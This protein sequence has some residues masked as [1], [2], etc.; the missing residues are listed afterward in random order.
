MAYEL[1]SPKSGSF[2]PWNTQHIS[3]LRQSI[4]SAEHALEKYRKNRKVLLNALHDPC[5]EEESPPTES[6]MPFNELDNMFQ[7]L[8][9]GVVDQN[10]TLRI[11]K[12]KSQRAA[13]MLRSK[14]HDWSERVHM[15][16]SLQSLFQECLLRWGIGYMGYEMGKSGV[17]PYLD[18]LDFDD[19]FI[20]MAGSDENDIDFEG[21]RLCRRLD[22]LLGNPDYNQE[23]VQKL[24]VYQDRRGYNDQQCTLYDRVDLTRTY[25]PREGLI[26]TMAG[27]HM[28]TDLPVQVKK[29]VGPPWGPYLRIHLGK[30]RSCMVPTSRASML[31]DLHDFVLRTYRHVFVQADRE[32]EAYAYSGE[33]EKD[34]EKHRRLQQ[35]EYIRMENP[36]GIVR[37]KKGGVNNSTLA[38]AMHA[39]DKFSE[40]AGNLK[41][42]GGL[43]PTAPTARQE[44]GLGV[45]VQQMIDHAKAKMNTLV[46]QIFD[47]AA[48]YMRLDNTHEEMVEWTTPN[49]NHV[50]TAWT[51]ETAAMLDPADTEMDIIPGSLV[52]RSAEQSLR[53]WSKRSR[54]SHG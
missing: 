26:V 43:G 4:D 18:V 45:G 15:S 52:S 46:R 51:P 13:G 8:T 32:I 31:Y 2:D 6:R 10:P 27:K 28:G 3:R 22:E 24:K 34:A 21:H 14:L 11:V 48:W 7:I 38:T 49:G 37:I 33:M 17:E 5:H 50:K 16:D 35:D 54:R 19:W 29:Y 42:A 44:A 30:V 41:L 23:E 1:T 40:R 9:R 39:S 36:A 53:S 20:D 12:A 25:L 47:T